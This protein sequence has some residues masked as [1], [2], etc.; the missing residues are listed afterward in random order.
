[1]KVLVIEDDDALRPEIVEYL[2][3]QHHDV[4]AADSLAAARG[5]LEGMLAKAAEAPQAIVCDVGLPD[6]DGVDFYI[7]FVDRVPECRWMLLSGGHDMSRLE[8]VLRGRVGPP[9]VIA[10]KPVPLR[11]LRDFLEAG[12]AGA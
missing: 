3:R 7:A 8:G 11:A 10:E 6:G 1:M 4:V 2:R 5:A 9:P 12:A